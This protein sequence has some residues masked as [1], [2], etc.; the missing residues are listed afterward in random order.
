MAKAEQAYD[1]AS[2]PVTGLGE[3]DTGSPVLPV[4]PA[5]F[6]DDQ[7]DAVIDRLDDETQALPAPFSK[8]DLYRTATDVGVP[9]WHSEQRELFTDQVLARLRYEWDADTRAFRPVI[10]E[11]LPEKITAVAD[12]IVPALDSE[13][14]QSLRQQ[15][16]AWCELHGFGAFE[17]PATQEIV[18]QQA[19]FGLLLRVTLYEWY[20]QHDGWPA[21]SDDPLEAVGQVQARSD[22]AGF[23]AWVLDDLAAL[24]DEAA[25]GALLEERFRILYSAQPAEDIGRVY[26]T[27]TLDE[28]R[29]VLGQYRTPPEIARLMRTW[30][31]SDDNQLLDPGMGPGGLSTPIHPLWDVSTNPKR[32]VGVDQSPLAALMGITAQT[33]A[34]QPHELR[35]ADFLALSPTDLQRDVDAVVCNPPYTR[36]NLLSPR[37]KDELITQAENETG[38]DIPRTSPLYAYFYYHLRQFLDTEGRAAVLTP[39]HFLAREYGVPLKRFLLREFDVKAFIMSDPDTGSRFENAET[40]ELVAFLEP[41]SADADTGVTRF[42]RVDEDPGYQTVLEAVRDNEQGETE[43]GFVNCINQADL[44][45][46]RKWDIFFDPIDVETTH[47]TPFSEL[48]DISRGLQTGENDFFCLSQA[49]VKSTGIDTQF[50]TRMVPPPRFVDGYDVRP[51]DWPKYSEQGRPTWLLYHVDSVEDV[52]E[53]TY[54]EEAECADWC[55]SSISTKSA[56]SVVEY[57]RHGLPNHEKLRKRSTVHTR[58]PWYRV[59]R[60]DTAPILIAPMTRSKVRVLLNETDARHLNSY[61]GIYPESTI[62]RPEQKALLAYLNSGFVDGIV[63]RHQRTLAGGLDKLEPGDV[64]KLPVIDP[65]ELADEVVDTLAA[66]FDELRTAARHNESEAAVIDRIDEVLQQEL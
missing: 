32:V 5:L 13:L 51:D 48:A 23:D 6:D 11:E 10:G 63:S 24:A 28:S 66:C 36:S 61:Y 56:S 17:D 39:H 38:V 58:D 45:P 9:V 65:R 20:H 30:A 50:L 15:T 43:W 18:A 57:L 16:E 42:I 19:V 26:E 44:E 21:L 52:P 53:T 41:R 55:E 59:E 29:R 64:K 34:G 4:R 49:D 62:G 14:S 46:E 27:V 31:A 3:S 60:G 33:L 2:S 40:T 35:T 37:Y 1:S 12:T 25:L 47:L 8:Q 7:V 54:D 22:A